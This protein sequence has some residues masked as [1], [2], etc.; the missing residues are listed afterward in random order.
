[1]VWYHAVSSNLTTRVA[2]NEIFACLFVFCKEC[3]KAAKNV[4][5][6]ARLISIWA[7]PALGFTGPYLLVVFM[8]IPT[9]PHPFSSPE[10][11]VVL[12]QEA[13]AQRHV[14]TKGGNQFE[15]VCVSIGL[16]SNC[17]LG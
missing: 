11:P 14:M 8:T 7:G 16:P 13:D 1:M 5:V 17:C 2:T 10:H 15:S 12:T 3:Q 6:T 4:G 9:L